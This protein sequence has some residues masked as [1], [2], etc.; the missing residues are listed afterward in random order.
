MLGGVRV[1]LFRGAR[2]MVESREY[3][4]AMGFSD[5]MR[6]LISFVVSK[7]AKLLV[8]ICSTC[9]VKGVVDRR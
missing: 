3:K 7:L 1:V 5:G 6:L 9:E 8:L 4:S 2:C